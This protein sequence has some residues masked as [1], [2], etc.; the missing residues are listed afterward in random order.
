MDD[1]KITGCFLKPSTMVLLIIGG[2]L[3][4]FYLPT[5]IVIFIAMVC[6]LKKNRWIAVGMYIIY[7]LVIGIVFEY[8]SIYTHWEAIFTISIPHLIALIEILKNKQLY[9]Y[10]LKVDLIYSVVVLFSLILKPLFVA[11]LVVK[12]IFLI[13][14]EFDLKGKVLF[15]VLCL[16]PIVIFIIFKNKLLYNNLTQNMLIVGFGLTIFLIWGYLKWKGDYYGYG[17]DL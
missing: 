9:H 7:L 16:I 17:G 14:D 12:F 8:S 6:I 3:E 11:L 2:I 5:L 4:N 1:T 15:M 13:A 10:T